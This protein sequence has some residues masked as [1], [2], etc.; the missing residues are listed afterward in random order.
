MPSTLKNGGFGKGK[1]VSGGVHGELREYRIAN[2]LATNLMPGDAVALNGTGT[3]VKVSTSTQVPLGVFVGLRPEGQNTFVPAHYFAS[4]ASVK[5]STNTYRALVNADPT[6][7]FEAQFDGSVSAGDVGLYFD[8]ADT[9]G[10]DTI[11]G[12][13]T[14][15]VH[16]SSRSSTSTDGVVQLVEIST[17][18]GN[19]VTDAYPYGVFKFMNPKLG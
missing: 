2:G 18:E 5:N 8:V 12:V 19:D 14:M 10:G 6:A 13:S 11:F 15:R 9:S 4:G 1:T 7:I 17:L 16:A 3:L